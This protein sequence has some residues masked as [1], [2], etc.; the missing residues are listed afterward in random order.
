ML[1]VAK[2][3]CRRGKWGTDNIGGG[4]VVWMKRM[5]DEGLCLCF[6]LSD[7]VIWEKGEMGTDNSGAV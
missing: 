5:G 2:L 4:G 3:A 6:L 1:I 7:V